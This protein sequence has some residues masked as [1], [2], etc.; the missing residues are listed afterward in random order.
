MSA[1]RAKVNVL[2]NAACLVVIA[3]CWPFSPAWFAWVV[4]GVNALAIVLNL[5]RLRSE[6]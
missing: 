5:L 2:V 4:V 6:I 1:R 3:A